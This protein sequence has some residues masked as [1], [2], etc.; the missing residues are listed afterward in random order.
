MPK[1]SRKR[2]K[3]R[4]RRPSTSS[5]SSSSPTPSRHRKRVRKTHTRRRSSSSSSS[6]SSSSSASRDRSKK[7]KR[8]KNEKYQAPES[9]QK[10]RDWDEPSSSQ[11]PES[12]DDFDENLKPKRGPVP[13]RRGEF[14]Q[15]T[16]QNPSSVLIIDHVGQ[17]FQCGVGNNLGL[18]QIFAEQ[19]SSI[20]QLLIGKTAKIRSQNK[21]T[22]FRITEL[23]TFRGKILKKMKKKFRKHLQ[24]PEWPFLVKGVDDSE[25]EYFPIEMAYLVPD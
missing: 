10:S 18:S 23:T 9:A 14:A 22:Y 11:I 2:T 21:S 20:K 15:A 8:R 1:E 19:M 6:N 17:L 13:C 5:D 12:D 24:K 4:R 16:T 7:H 25:L 3:K